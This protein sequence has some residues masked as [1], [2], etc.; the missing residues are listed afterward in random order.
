MTSDN[1]SVNSFVI[2][3]FAPSLSQVTAVRNPTNDNSPD[4]TFYSGEA[5]DITYGGS[6]GSNSYKPTKTSAEADNN[7]VTFRNLV[8]NTT[9]SDCTIT[10]TDNATNA[11]SALAVNT[12]TVDT[13]SP[14]LNWVIPGGLVPTPD[15]D[16]TP[17]FTFSSNEA[18][19]ITYGGSCG[20]SSSSAAT[21][22]DNTVTLTQ[23]DNST[24]LS[25]GTYSNCY[26]YVTDN[27]TNQSNIRV[28]GWTQ[29]GSYANYFFTVGANKP[30]LLQITPV[31]TSSNDNTSTYTFYSTLPGTINYSGSC[32]SDNDTT[33]LADNN[34]VTFNALPDGT[35][36]DCKIS[37]T[38]N[39]NITSDN[40]TVSSFTIDTT[41]PT[42]SSLT[43]HSNN[44]NA[45]IARVGNIVTL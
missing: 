34:T 35:H 7:T 44:D 14:T 43:I 4:Y 23:P 31:P 39:D 33:A 27:A 38:T 21:S 13:V 5:G 16:S 42:L 32:D 25:D 11:S 22:G 24:A 29:A 18:G 36:N 28:R 3:T 41:A 12:F 9:Y 6:C 15:N 26:I 37:V 1:L 8:H 2:D 19:D 17:D 10:V 45:T 20:S 40:L 30:A